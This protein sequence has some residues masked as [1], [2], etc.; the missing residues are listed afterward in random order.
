M[1]ECT[2]CSKP[3]EGGAGW[4][5]GSRTGCIYDN[6]DD[7]LRINNPR[8]AGGF[9]IPTGSCIVFMNDNAGGNPVIEGDIYKLVIYDF[10]YCY[11]LCYPSELNIKLNK[12]F[13]SEP[14]GVA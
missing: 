11:K 3:G 2:A 10:G 1:A 4:K 13:L 5:Y 6:F 7:C 8:K 12:L 9:Y 14:K